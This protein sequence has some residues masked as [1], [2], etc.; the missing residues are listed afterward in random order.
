VATENHLHKNFC[1]ELLK[2]FCLNSGGFPYY[3]G[4]EPATE[5]TLLSLL[6]LH[7]ENCPEQQ[8]RPSL[9]WILNLQNPDGSIGVNPVHH[10]EGVWLTAHLAIVL[11]CYGLQDNCNRALEFLK[12]FRSRSMPQEEGVNQN[13]TLVG[14]PWVHDTFGW[15][16]PTAW[17]LLAF[18]LCG[19]QNDPR[20][21]EGRK[22]LMDRCI[23]SGGWNYGNRLINYQELL[24]FYD[25]TALALLALA[26]TTNP[27]FLNKSIQLLEENKDHIESIYGLSLAIICL[28][29]YRRNVSHLCDVL[30]ERIRISQKDEINVAHLALATV[31][32]SGRRV[33]TT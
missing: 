10:N 29:C 27:S 23:P 8:T 13:N 16:E 11:R 24:P 28:S 12:L 30:L 4:K 31:A 19:L 25:T 33:L 26:G 6:A 21:V 9:N 17:A 7:A 1:L 22:L 15:V 5:P 20:A 18:N 14:W 2:S 3:S 32:L